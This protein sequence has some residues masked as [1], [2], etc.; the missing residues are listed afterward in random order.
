M[1]M[2]RPWPQE[3]AKAFRLEMELE[4]LQTASWLEMGLG[5]LQTAYW[6]EMERVSQHH[7]Q[8]QRSS[9]LCSPRQPK[10]KLSP[11]QQSSRRLP[12]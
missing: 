5:H 9:E 4:H 10:R 7:F 1:L 12:A 2:M 11:G 6:L 3:P 8:R